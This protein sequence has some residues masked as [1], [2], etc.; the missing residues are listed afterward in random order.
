M[1]AMG[2]ERAFGSFHPAATFVVIAAAIVLGMLVRR[3]SYVA[4]GLLCA[5]VSYYALRGRAGRRVLAGAAGA[6]VLVA[7]MNPLFSPLGDTV[8]FRFFDGRPYTLEALCFGAS[9]GA[10]LAGTLMWCGCWNAVM[11]SDKLMYLLGGVAPALSLV[12][13][14]VLRLVPTYERRIARFA[15]ARAGIG[16][17]VDAGSPAARVRRAGALLSQLTTWALESGLVTADSMRARGFGS[18]SRAS[19]ASYRLHRRDVVL[20]C[21]V[22]IGVLII[23]AGMATGAQDVSYYPVFSVA[24]GSPLSAAGLAAY[25]A[26]LSLPALITAKEALAWRISLSRI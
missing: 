8:L 3:P 4:V 23:G 9:T 18:S 12:L 10:A 16:L 11:T 17:S 14:M 2:R 21:C 15:A 1:A 22:G 5:V 7:V 19:Y 26:L 25:A 13:S 24:L 6:A 20:L